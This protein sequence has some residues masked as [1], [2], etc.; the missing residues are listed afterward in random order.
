[1]TYTNEKPTKPGWYW[2][3]SR[4]ADKQIAR[5]LED[6]DVIFKPRSGG[7]TRMKMIF[8]LN[9]D[10]QFAGP[11]PEPGKIDISTHEQPNQYL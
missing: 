9:D 8:V 6:G 3:R 2:F 7:E 1:M 10:A 4:H 11:I 5:L